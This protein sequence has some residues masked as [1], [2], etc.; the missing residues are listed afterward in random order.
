MSTELPGSQQLRLAGPLPD[1]FVGSVLLLIDLAKLI[2]YLHHIN[3]EDIH[4]G[5]VFIEWQKH[6]LLARIELSGRHDSDH[7]L[8][9]SWACW[10]I[11]AA[12]V[13]EQLLRTATL[14]SYATG[15]QNSK[16]FDFFR[17]ALSLTQLPRI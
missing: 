15:C 3:P 17:M 8:Q 6:R 14:P 13:V 12:A 1:F 11:I 5:N 9:C 7:W 2:L 10:Q 16:I 4:L